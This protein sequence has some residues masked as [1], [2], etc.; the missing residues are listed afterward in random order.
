M[1]FW[2]SKSLAE[3]STEEWESLCDGCGKC[4]LNKLID[5]DTEKLYY[6]NSACKLLNLKQC[7]CK[8]YKNRLSIIPECTVIKIQDL[9]ELDWLPESCAY[10]RLY[11]GQKLPSWHPLITGSKSEMHKKGM[12]VRGK[13]VCKTKIDDIE[14][15]IVSWPLEFIE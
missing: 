6:T 11:L 12:S 14:N 3:M 4:C 15:H 7:S 8:K 5:D 10:K 9:P 2:E 13:A 1:P